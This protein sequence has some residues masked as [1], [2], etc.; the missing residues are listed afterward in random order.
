MTVRQVFYQAVV[1][2]LIEKSEAGYSRVQRALVQMRRD[3]ALPYS[4][5]A[6]YSRLRRQ[7]D[8]FDSI[9]EA[10]EI[11]A[12]CYRRAL[13]SQAG[14]YVEVWCEKN[15]LLGVLYPVT[16]QFD[17]PLMISGG[18]SSDT[19]IY[20]TA[21]EMKAAGRPCWVY[22]FGDR[23]PSGVSISQTLEKKLRQF[24]PEV[25]L[26][27]ERIAVTLE[28]IEEFNLPTRPTKRTDSRAKGWE[29]ESVELDAIAPDTL[30]GLVRE[31]IERHIDPVHLEN[32]QLTEDVERET[33]REI[34]AAMG[35]AV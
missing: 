9:A 29:G 10:L 14:A 31:C 12:E 8:T 7:P 4:W 28:Q 33:I 17:V 5:I 1:R 18:F 35:G 20:G 16:A 34:A 6:D 11:T 21:E 2:N 22:E 32:L 26:H 23:D 30:R 25:E 15:A 3:G 13:W 24:A 19:F 27:F